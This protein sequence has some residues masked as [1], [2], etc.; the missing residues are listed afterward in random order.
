MKAP[1][2]PAEDAKAGVKIDHVAKRLALV[3]VPLGF[4][5][6]ARQ[7]SRAVGS[8]DDAHWQIVHLQAGQWN[9]G[10]RGEFHV[11]LVLQ[12]PALLRLLAQRE[13]RGWL[14][15]HADKADPGL[16]PF[17]ER[18]AHL[19]SELPATH[20]CTRPAIPD[21]YTF[22]RGSDL[23]ALADDVAQAVVQVGLPWLQQHG[24]LRALAD[25]QGSLLTADVEVRL[26]AALLLGDHT[27]AQQILVE[28]R[29][30]FEQS[31]N[32][33]LASVRGWLVGLGMEVSAL[34]A[35]VTPAQPSAWEHKREAAQRAEE[36]QH[37]QHA[38]QIRAQVSAA[39]AAVPPPAALAEAWL[40]EHR[41]AWRNDPAPLA[42][43]PSGR[44]VA[45]LDANGRETVLCALLQHLVV[46]EQ[47]QT[48]PRDP[49]QPPVDS[50]D[51]DESVKLLLVALLPTLPSATES[52]V[53][54]VLGQMRT[55]VTRWQ[56]ELVTGGYPW[57]FATLVR[58]LTGPAGAPHRAAMQPAI[59]AWLA[60][61]AHFAVA[62]HDRLTDLVATDE[63][64]AED[65]A[66]PLHELMREARER[67]AEL[68]AQQALP[69]AEEVRRRITAYPEQRMSGADKQA[70]ATLRREG[71]RD[72]AT[73]HLPVTWDDDDWG[74]VAAPAWQ[75]LPAATRDAMAPVLQGWLEGVET[76]PS[77]TWLRTLAA[78]AAQVAQ[79]GAAD[80]WRAWVLQQLAAFAP[81]SGRTEWATTGA[82]PGVGARLGEASENLLLGLLWWAWHDTALDAATL[83]E[84]LHHVST[85]A[86]QRLPDVGA[87]APTVGGLVLR[88]RAGLG[89]A[90][91]QQVAALGAGRGVPKQRQ[92]AVERALKEPLAR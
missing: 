69:S 28:R 75:A 16:G 71:R 37:A 78:Q 57:G 12:W 30:R 53:L 15:D 66:H 90:A 27:R 56:Q 21:T 70:V 1:E 31:N 83:D 60:A 35:T 81:S 63:A 49:V 43:L 68:A 65:P 64:A 55:L 38:Q 67:E 52:T 51:A 48:T 7:F 76:R 72:A 8:G 80:V 86:W 62:A 4:K 26:A 14:A 20:P 34:P 74:Q 58:W 47:Q 2:L 46:R 3:L 25:F 32:T 88:M 19:Q 84:A 87:R 10:P 29:A 45:A 13:G 85:G 41:A 9:E 82:R 77:K 23:A 42:D 92:Q 44:D 39:P 6:K 73:G 91:Q 54:T 11:N 89:E 50:F 17:S 61:Y 40:A 24:S 22:G 18:L 36:T 33:Y 5:R 79:A 59:A